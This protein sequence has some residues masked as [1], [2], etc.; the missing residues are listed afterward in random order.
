[1]NLTLASV[2][3]VSPRPSDEANSAFIS[4]ICPRGISS[5]PSGIKEVRLGRPAPRPEICPSCL[6]MLHP[7]GA[8]SIG[9]FYGSNF[10]HFGGGKGLGLF[11]VWTKKPAFWDFI[12][13]LQRDFAYEPYML[14]F[15]LPRMVLETL[16]GGGIG[17]KV[18]FQAGGKIHLLLAPF[19]SL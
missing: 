2:T 11:W 16:S 8:P 1:V 9:R 14:Y 4:S 19:L 12:G 18:H 13:A 17:D 10:D 15:K 3:I 7:H 6:N 5:A